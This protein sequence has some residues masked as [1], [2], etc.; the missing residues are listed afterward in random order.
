MVYY[1]LETCCG[2][3]ISME[4]YLISSYW[5]FN[6]ENTLMKRNERRDYVMKGVNSGDICTRFI[7]DILELSRSLFAE[8]K[9]AKI[10]VIAYNGGRFDLLLLA[11]Y[12]FG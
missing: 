2:D 6:K 12:I 3:G 10:R 9:R 1:D 8:N 5:T 4:P 11:K 7:F